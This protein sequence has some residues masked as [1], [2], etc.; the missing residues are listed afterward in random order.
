MMYS[1]PI[2]IA[3]ASGRGIA[4]AMSEVGGT[5]WGTVAAMGCYLWIQ[6]SR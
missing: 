4:L 5:G 3:L 2:G 1:W 6:I